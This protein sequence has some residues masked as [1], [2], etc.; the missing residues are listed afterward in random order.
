MIPMMPAHA[1]FWA[2]CLTDSQSTV[3]ATTKEKSWFP[4]GTRLLA[5]KAPMKATL[6]LTALPTVL[7][8]LDSAILTRPMATPSLTEAMATS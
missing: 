8:H 3:G 5:Q 4:A 7:V 1:N 6:S 2:T